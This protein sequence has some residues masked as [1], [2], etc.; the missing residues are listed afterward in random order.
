MQVAADGGPAVELT[1]VSRRF[2]EVE[3]VRELSLRVAAGQTLALIGPS[4]CGKSTLLRLMNGLLT[5]DRG[6]VSFEGSALTAA[7][8]MEQRRRMGYVV[9]TGGLFPH[10][11][12]KD[13]VTLLARYLGFEPGKLEARLG[14]LAELVRLPLDLLERFPGQLSG[15]QGQRVS[16]MR[17]LMM[18]PS[19]LLLDEPLGS[20]DPMVRAALQ[21]DLRELFGSLGK[22]VVLVT[23]DLAEARYLGERIVLMRGG[24]IVQDGTYEELIER[25]ASEFVTEFVRAQRL[26]TD[27]GGTA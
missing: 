14:E 27:A 11:T 10:L 21:E 25:P 5:P 8:S 18:D 4:G 16:L 24:E 22:T 20:L 13:N 9:Q 1:D 3:A 6:E 2:G 23:H 12:A 17:A 15:G 26:M 7:S 19:V